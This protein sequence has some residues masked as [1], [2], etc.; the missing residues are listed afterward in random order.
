LQGPPPSSL[1]MANQKTKNPKGSSG[2]SGIGGGSD[3]DDQE[4][5]RD[6]SSPRRSTE[7]MRIVGLL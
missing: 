1:V 7:T 2:S 3:N 4:D 5:V 6:D